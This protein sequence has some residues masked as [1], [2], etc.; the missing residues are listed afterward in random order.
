MQ[1][2]DTIAAIA[3]QRRRTKPGID[4]YEQFQW[5]ARHIVQT[6]FRDSSVTFEQD[7]VEVP[8]LWTAN[9]SEIL[10]SKYLRCLSNRQDGPDVIEWVEQG[11]PV[12]G[13]KEHSLRQAL[14]RIVDTITQAGIQG[15]YF[16]I[17]VGAAFNQELKCLMLEQRA[18]FNTPV[19]FNIGVPG[20]PQQASA[21]FIL[22]VDDNIPSIQRWFQDETTVFL[23]GSG[24]GVNVSNIRSSHERL[25][26]G[27][28]ATGPLSFMRVAD[29][30]ASV[31]KCLAAGTLVTTAAGPQPIESLTVDTLVQTRRGL[32][33][34]QAVFSNGIKPLLRIDTDMGTTVRC[35][36]EHKF[37]VRHSD[38]TEGWCEAGQLRTDDYLAV[39]VSG[40]E[41][42]TLQPLQPPAAQKYNWE[43]AINPPAYLNEP[44]A[45]W[46][47]WVCGDGTVS[48]TWRRDKKTNTNKSSR[49]IDTQIGDI[50]AD[51]VA[52]YTGLVHQLFSPDI[53]VFPHR[54]QN[55]ADASVSM[56]FSSVAVERFLEINGLRKATL[57]LNGAPSFVKAS[58]LPVKAAFLAGLFEADGTA[59]KDW[60]VR[61]CTVSEPLMRDAQQMLLELGIPAVLRTS[62][63][64]PG[65]YTKPGDQPRPIWELSVVSTLGLQRFAKL[66]GFRSQ[67]KQT[68]LAATLRHR[69]EFGPDVEKQWVL[70]HVDK[71]L[72]EAWERTN[73]QALRRS[74]SGTCRRTNV[75]C[76][77]VSL[78]HALNLLDRF[79]ELRDTE[80]ERLARGD[81]YWTTA[82]VTAGGTGPTYDLNIPD[83][84]EYQVS[85]LVV[86]NSGAG[87]R[88]AAK[89]VVMDADHPDIM[90]YIWC[91]ALEER[92]AAALKD[93]GYDTDLDGTD[94]ISIQYQNANNSVR[95]TDQFMQMALDG[96]TWQLRARTTGEVITEIEAA[97]VLD[98]IAEAAWECADPGVQ[99]T[100]TINRWH[101]LSDLEPIQASNPC[102]L[103][104][105]TCVITQDGPVLIE[106]IAGRCETGQDLPQ[107]TAFDETSG[108]F[109]TRTATKAW[110]AG[111]AFELVQV[112]TSSGG[113][114]RCTPEHRF[115]VRDGSWVQAKDLQ[116]GTDLVSAVFGMP[117]T[118]VA[119]QL[120][121][122]DEPVPV[123]DLEVDGAHNFAVRTARGGAVVVHNSEYLSLD[124]T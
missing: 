6:S 20:A 78:A 79:P 46:L 24:A 10:A 27:L 105:E 72:N 9:A 2:L 82:T 73:D 38:G 103:V 26:S 57:A 107:V 95:L 32:K 81:I 74:L 97:K 118:V 39:D 28:K 96:G 42:G 121:H 30:N 86:H 18:S 116:P 45:E 70:P 51:L 40:S 112:S 113:V 11:K 65:K 124:N 3:G 1:S 114:L 13:V 84:H 63:K 67:R 54:K 35:T 83:V 62:Q 88:K 61:A 106:D 98:A 14:D 80:L 17:E 50:D 48:S 87:Q 47:G 99:F 90:E 8:V 110:V 93:A 108:V 33:P 43:T 60:R 12:R 37:W 71:C 4:V 119:V 59:K 117:E 49:Y 56:R 100:D 89:M 23:G 29:T 123:Y 44:L 92:K 111:W 85:G 68:R 22:H 31:L 104:G 101:T 5:E 109:G 19:W 76:T 55:K 77:R 102:C 41:C 75:Q 53:S 34:I 58:P 122:L 64:G 91:K 120:Q 25:S 7:G 36:A 21:C 52:Y 16:D 115:L 15:G 69:G 94:M 66:V